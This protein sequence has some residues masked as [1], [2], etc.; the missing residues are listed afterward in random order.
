MSAR[1][2]LHGAILRLKGT[3]V[4]STIN[5][6]IIGLFCLASFCACKDEAAGVDE[7][8]GA[9]GYS[10]SASSAGRSAA[11][12]GHG[13]GSDAGAPTGNDA[14]SSSFADGGDVGAGGAGQGGAHAIV[15]NQI[16][17]CKFA[18][19]TDRATE[20]RTRLLTFCDDGL[21]LLDWTNG[22]F[23]E[24]AAVRDYSVGTIFLTSKSVF[25]LQAKQVI[26]VALSGG[27]PETVDID[28]ES[29][30]ASPDR[31]RLLYV[32]RAPTPDAAFGTFLLVPPEAKTSAAIEATK[33]NDDRVLNPRGSFSPDGQA[34]FF[35][36]TDHALATVPVSGHD[37]VTIGFPYNESV[38]GK[39]G[40][41]LAFYDY[42]KEQIIVTDVEGSKFVS[43]GDV[44]TDDEWTPLLFSHD[45]TAVLFR[46][47]TLL[48]TKPEARLFPVDG[49]PSYLI[50]NLPSFAAYGFGGT[51]S[52]LFADGTDPQASKQ[53]RLWRNEKI[54][55]LG[56]LESCGKATVSDDGTRAAFLDVAGTFHG[57]DL[58]S[59]KELGALPEVALIGKT[60]VNNLTWSPDAQL[61]AFFSCDAQ[62][63]CKSFIVSA[64]GARVST[65]V[66]S[67]PETFEFSPDSRYINCDSH[68]RSLCDTSTGKMVS[69]FS[70]IHYWIDT[71]H[72]VYDAGTLFSG[73]GS[74]LSLV[75]LP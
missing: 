11:N 71:N 68:S 20:D 39:S 15:S 46:Q 70:D 27:K 18:S 10:G 7:S 54:S 58:V 23:L 43:V 26:R 19:D 32:R 22:D 59:G 4:G 21:G 6:C 73:G 28:V 38:Y 67:N 69:P 12:A 16:G 14:G 33:T 63:D 75:T 56:T 3:D 24:L 40:H 50:S 52:L 55:P 41:S 29:L 17:D 53:I 60:C 2:G 45:E 64:Q 48:S 72:V 5:T 1:P 42:D 66:G 51:G 25:Y 31:K 44:A 62:G 13:Y 36:T 49:S 65:L 9:S 34:V 47:P 61:V 37:A 35:N 8:G 30:E 74:G 57:I